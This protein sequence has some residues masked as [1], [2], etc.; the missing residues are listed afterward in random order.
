[1]RIYLLAASIGV[2][3]A[4]S[5]H[6]S[7]PWLDSPTLE[8][9]PP[10]TVG[11]PAHA[12]PPDNPD[13]PGN[14]DGP[15]DGV[16][17]GPPDGAGPP[18]DRGPP[19]NPGQG[20]GNGPPENLPVPGGDGPPGLALGGDLAPGQ[21]EDEPGTNIPGPAGQAGASH[22]AHVDFV[23]LDVDGNIAASED[24]PWGRMT[25]FWQA[26]SL[27]LVFNAHNLE[28]GADYVLAAEIDGGVL[29]LAEGMANEDGDLHLLASLEMDSHLPMDLDPEN[30]DS[31]ATGVGLV[32]LPA[33]AVDCAS[34][35]VSGDGALFST[36][37]IFYVDTDLLGGG[38]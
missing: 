8:N 1:M 24:S 28:P 36:T 22:T 13:P 19:E 7:V 4:G 37:E 11:P 10:A 35:A 26:S 12:G 29:C 33:D 21:C 20:V 16:D 23:G 32:V 3:L 31:D 9:G 2:A 27:D 25:Y 14:D 34:G 5:A 15:P 18:A 38:G 30:E 17:T 6:A